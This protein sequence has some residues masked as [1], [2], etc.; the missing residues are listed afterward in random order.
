MF[1]VAQSQPIGCNH[2]VMLLR[3]VR[4]RFPGEPFMPMMHHDA[5]G[6]RKTLEFPVPVPH[7]RHGTNDKG[8]A[9][10][11]LDSTLP[12]TEKEA[13]KLYSIVAKNVIRYKVVI[14]LNLK[15]IDPTII[16]NGLNFLNARVVHFLLQQVPYMCDIISNMQVICPALICQQFMRQ[17]DS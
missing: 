1:F 13:D 8:W 9:R 11:F 12:V 6:W 7:N 5:Q 4:E 14:A 10:G 2:H 15:I 16:C 3:Y 17:S